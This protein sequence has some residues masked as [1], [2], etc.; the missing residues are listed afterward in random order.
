MKGMRVKFQ[1]VMRLKGR[2]W[3][4]WREG[5]RRGRG[6]ER[7]GKMEERMNGRNEGKDGMMEERLNGRNEGGDG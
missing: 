4:V 2:M 5:R 1:W 6:G 7:D 3:E